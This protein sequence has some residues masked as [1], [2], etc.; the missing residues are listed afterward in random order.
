MQPPRLSFAVHLPLRYHV[1]STL[2]IPPSTSCQDGWDPL[3]DAEPPSVQATRLHAGAAASTSSQLPLAPA[4]AAKPA[5]T[6]ASP[7]PAAP[8]RAAPTTAAAPAPK[9]AATAPTVPAVATSAAAKPP[10]AAPV[11]AAPKATAAAPKG[12]PT[13][14]SATLASPV[15]ALPAPSAAAAG[16]VASLPIVRREVST[17]FSESAVHNGVVYLAGQVPERTLFQGIKTQT[18]EVLDAVDLRLAAAGSSKARILSA[19]CYLADLADLQGFNQTWD[20]WV[21][22]GAAPPR[23]TIGAPLTRPEY[24]IEIV[25]TAA[26]GL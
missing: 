1:A 18:S 26:V 19:T 15:C 23:A 11:P 8:K 4:V 22:A 17:R 3:H 5:A 24:R 16:P 12:P 20:A 9:P 13:R 7:P 2:Q 21:P 14:A 10:A 25:I 6:V